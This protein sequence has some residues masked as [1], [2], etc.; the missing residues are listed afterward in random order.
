MLYLG[1]GKMLNPS[2]RTKWLPKFN[3]EG[4]SFYWLSGKALCILARW[5]QKWLELTLMK[6]DMGLL[7]IN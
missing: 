7:N 1:R 4:S 3:R 2:L 5:K 6:L